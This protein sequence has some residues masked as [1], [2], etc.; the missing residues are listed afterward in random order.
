MDELVSKLNEAIELLQELLTKQMS[1]TEMY[2]NKCELLES[3]LNAK[4]K[5]ER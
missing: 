4:E 5:A 2:K 1:L 3:E